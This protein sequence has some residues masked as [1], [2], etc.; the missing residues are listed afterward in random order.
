MSIEVDVVGRTSLGDLDGLWE[1]NNR[2]RGYLGSIG[3][4]D[5]DGT[6]ARLC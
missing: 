6:L 4:L 5:D 3:G 2:V 1:Q